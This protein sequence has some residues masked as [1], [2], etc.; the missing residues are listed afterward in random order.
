MI[1]GSILVSLAAIGGL[2]LALNLG[3]DD[4]DN[5]GGTGSGSTPSASV[6]QTTGTGSG[7]GYK[8][9]DLS[10]KIDAEE[11]SEARESYTD[12]DK[13]QLPDFRYKNLASVK[14]CFQAAGWRMKTTPYAENTYGKDQVMDQ[15]PSAGE[16]VDPE[17]MPVIE[18]KVSTGYPPS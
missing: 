1:V 8:G 15:F 5:G 6:S 13:I 4:T 3:G 12:P 10:K 7:T 16:D 9:P 17:D 14:L 11:C 18:L 2:I